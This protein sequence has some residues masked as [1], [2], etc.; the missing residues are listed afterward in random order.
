MQSVSNKLT[1]RL[2]TIPTASRGELIA[3]EIARQKQQ[4]N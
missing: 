4:E 1:V 2:V 3:F